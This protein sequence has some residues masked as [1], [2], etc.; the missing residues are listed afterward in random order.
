MYHFGPLWGAHLSCYA[1]R[2]L[3]HS[4]SSALHN[5]EILDAQL[6]ALRIHQHLKLLELL[7]ILQSPALSAL[8]FIEIRS[9]WHVSLGSSGFEAS[10][11]PL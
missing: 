9:F 10:S 5:A 6:S 7:M 1:G 2:N 8:R 3:R 4:I 11:T